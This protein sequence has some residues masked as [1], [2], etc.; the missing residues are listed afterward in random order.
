[1]YRPNINQAPSPR[2]LLDF[3]F[4]GTNDSRVVG[5]SGTDFAFLFERPCHVAHALN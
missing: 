5:Q 2:T 3:S 1:M 4:R